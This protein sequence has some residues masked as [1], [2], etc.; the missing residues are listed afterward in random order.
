MKERT[1]ENGILVIH[2]EDIPDPETCFILS[3]VGNRGIREQ[4]RTFLKSKGYTK[5][6]NFIALA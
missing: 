5:G 2:H 6:K 3:M 1:P 4:I